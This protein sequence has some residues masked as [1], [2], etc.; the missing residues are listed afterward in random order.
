MGA[1]TNVTTILWGTAWTSGTLLAQMI[2]HLQ[3]LQAQDCR[4]RVFKDDADRVG[5]EV[6]ACAAYVAGEDEA[7]G[8]TTSER[9][10]GKRE[11]SNWLILREGRREHRDHC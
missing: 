3:R 2:Q 9:R 11:W 10:K 6:P 4:R 7:E 8:D 5:A 1:S